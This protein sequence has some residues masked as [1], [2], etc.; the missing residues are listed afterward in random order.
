MTE[1]EPE[2]APAPSPVTAEPQTPDT[3]EQETDGSPPLDQP[4]TDLGPLGDLLER[5]GF[6]DEREE[7]DR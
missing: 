6:D 4:M 7:G 1:T 2:P 5:L 3:R